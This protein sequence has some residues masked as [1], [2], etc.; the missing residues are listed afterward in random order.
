[1]VRQLQPLPSFEH[2][3][4]WLLNALE[5]QRP[6]EVRTVSIKPL[7]SGQYDGSTVAPVSERHRKTV[8]GP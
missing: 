8:A 5:L 4:G 3:L 1:M 6:D 2:I 7:A